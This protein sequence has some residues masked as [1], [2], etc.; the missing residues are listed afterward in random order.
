MKYV[1]GNAKDLVNILQTEYPL[2]IQH[3]NREYIERYGHNLLLP[4]CSAYVL[5]LIYLKLIRHNS[6]TYSSKFK[7]MKVK[8]K[9]WGGF[10][11]K[12]YEWV[13]KQPDINEIIAFSL[14]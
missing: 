13:I 10:N 7:V 11:Q 8:D 1:K 14:L 5:N 6:P 9:D 3:I 2:L 12:I 4:D